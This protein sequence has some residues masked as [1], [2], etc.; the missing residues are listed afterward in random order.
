MLS[1]IWDV[2][3]RQRDEWGPNYLDEG[4]AP[5]DQFTIDEWGRAADLLGSRGA[6]VVWLTSPCTAQEGLT[7]KARYANATYIPAL[8]RAHAVVKVDLSAHV[9]PAGD[10]TDRL[11]TV[12]G[13]RPDGVHF[14]DP[15]RGLGRGVVGPST[16]RPLPPE[17]HRSR[18]RPRGRPL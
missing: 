18:P 16:R 3:A 4:D 13:G 2:G 14:S 8:V 11:G 7:N 10:F 1:T 15:G 17:R 6:R 9:C 12:D 5:F